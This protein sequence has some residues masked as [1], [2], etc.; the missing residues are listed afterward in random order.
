GGVDH[1]VHNDTGTAVDLTDNVHDFGYVGAR[2]TLVDNCQIR[3]QLFGQR[4]GANH[5]TNVGR[6][7]HQVLEIALTD[8]GQQHGAG[9]D[10]VYRDIEK[11]LNLVG[12]QVHGKQAIN[13]HALQHVGN[14]FCR[15]GHTC[16]PRAAILAGVAKIRNGGSN[17]ASRGAAQR[18]DHRHDFHEIIV[19]WRAG[20]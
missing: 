17:S 3:F 15:D 5:T 19:G 1:V 18:I 8:I 13:P 16:R 9:I 20:G 7:N 2:A 12:V 14:H 10:V 11:T 6:N 4:T